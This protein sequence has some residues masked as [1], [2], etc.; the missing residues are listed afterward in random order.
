[1]SAPELLNN[2]LSSQ[3]SPAL[4][5]L[6]PAGS[7]SHEAL[8]RLL[9][10]VGGPFAACPYG[11]IRQLLLAVAHQKL[12]AAVVPVENALE[13]SVADVLEPLGQ[14]R[15]GLAVVLEWS[16]PIRHCL[17]VTAN[18]ERP[19]GRVLSHPQALGQCRENLWQR[20]GEGVMAQATAST[21]EAIALVAAQPQDSVERWAAIGSK[22]AAQE[23]GLVVLDED[24]SDAPGNA[25]RFF[26]VTAKDSG[27][28]LNLKPGL[29]Q[30]TSFCFSTLDEPG[31]LVSVLMCFKNAGINL[32]KIE[33][34]PSR[35]QL[36]EYVFYVDATGD[37]SQAAQPAFFK[38]LM[39]GVKTC[40][41]MGPYGCLGHLD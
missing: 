30:K 5:Y 16:I 37:W 35:R 41:V 27:L 40:Q 32:S 21:S 24:L 29:A 11:S 8:K 31:A 1:M 6:G 39:Q 38:A 26:L 3:E 13:G 36:G 2:P 15:H 17:A 18:D 4:G 22:W 19:I 9:D 10:C 23:A 12:A 14:D 34:R 20:F 25:T 28:V 33:S 7:H